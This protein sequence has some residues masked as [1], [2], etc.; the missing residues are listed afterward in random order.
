M[1]RYLPTCI[2]MF[3]LVAVATAQ[4]PVL[5]TNLDPGQADS[6]RKA[7]EPV[8]QMTEQQMLDLIPTQSGLYFVS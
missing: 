4:H 7:V 6:L 5:S 8:M 2:M 3:A 1:T